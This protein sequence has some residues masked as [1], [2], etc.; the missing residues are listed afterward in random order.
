M[1]SIALSSSLSWALNTPDGLDGRAEHQINGVL[2]NLG[3]AV[4]CSGGLLN[5]AGDMLRVREAIPSLFLEIIGQVGD[6]HVGNLIEAVL[7]REHLHDGMAEYGTVD[8]GTKRI[9]L[10]EQV[11]QKVLLLA[12]QVVD[13]MVPHARQALK[14]D[15]LLL[16][17]DGRRQTAE[18]Q[19]IGDDPGIDPIGLV[20][21]RVSFPELVDK[22]RIDREHLG[23]PL[24]KRR[25]PHA[26]T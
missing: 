17:D 6:I 20:Q 10:V 26:G 25:H 14:R 4:R 2:H 22:L 21:V 19:A 13:Q 9:A 23:F 24:L 3:K 8:F 11:L 12:R 15:V 16:H 1:R 5:A 7:F 18:A